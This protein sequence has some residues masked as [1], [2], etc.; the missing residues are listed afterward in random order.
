M[1]TWYFLLLASTLNGIRFLFLCSRTTY[2]LIYVLVTIRVIIN[3]CSCFL[4]VFFLLLSLFLLF[5][6]D[7]IFYT[8]RI[9]IELLLRLLRY[10][11]I[12]LTDY[13]IPMILFLSSCELLTIQT[14]NPIC[15]NAHV[16]VCDNRR[17]SVFNNWLFLVYWFLS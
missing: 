11:S 13:L 1:F 15:L 17:Q 2:W 16:A 7:F 3:I 10:I 8:I 5:L 6:F 14:Y 4:L 12:E 9:Y